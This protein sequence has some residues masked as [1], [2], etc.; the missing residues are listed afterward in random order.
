MGLFTTS[1]IPRDAA[2]GMWS[3]RR[4]DPESDEH[5]EYA[6]HISLKP[7]PDVVMTPKSVDGTVDYMS[8][9]MA[10]IN[11]PTINK[12]AN[13]YPR[14]EDHVDGQGRGLAIVVFYAARTIRAGKELTW[15]YGQNYKRDYPVGRAAKVRDPPYNARRVCKMLQSNRR[16][17]LVYLD[18]L[19]DSTSGSDT[20]W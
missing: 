2:I 8:H 9:P 5:D 11:E 3:G 12:M 7:Y 16:D 10:A 20:S 4:L 13:V 19:E 17:V 6:M 14:V 1:T 18:E 15:H